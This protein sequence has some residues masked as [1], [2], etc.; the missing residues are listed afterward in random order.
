[1]Q[2]Y[3]NGGNWLEYRTK[4]HFCPDLGGRSAEKTR[5]SPFVHRN[6][7]GNAEHSYVWGVCKLA[8]HK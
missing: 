4:L 3:V 8:D 5:Q 2:F 6:S 7:K 1:M